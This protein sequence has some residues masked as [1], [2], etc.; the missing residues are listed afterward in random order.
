[1]GDV[2]SLEAYKESLISQSFR[3]S[4]INRKIYG[5]KAGLLGYL[6]A[7][8]GK[9]KGELLGQA[10]KTVKGIKLSKGEKAVRPERVLSEEEIEKLIAAVDAK[11][12]LIIRFLAVTGCRISEALNVKLGEIKLTDEAVEVSVIGKGQKARTVFISL[13]DYEAIRETFKGAEFLFETIH[14]NRYDKVNLTKKIGKLSQAVLGKR[15]TCHSFRHSFATNR[16]KATGKIAG[17]SSYLGH[18][19]VSTT[20]N[21]YVHESLT[22]AEL[23]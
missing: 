4:S 12:A 13:A 5:I 1:M 11:T 19:S 20:M 7:V 22:L 6:K 14:H 9:E 16:I 21:L 15:A 18:S 8:Y 17:V 10:Y 3:P 23:L 2:D